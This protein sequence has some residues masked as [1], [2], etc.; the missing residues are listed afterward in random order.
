MPVHVV[1]LIRDRF[2]VAGRSLKDSA[3]LICGVAYKENTDDIRNSHGLEI[4]R[5][6]KAEGAD[7]LLWDPNVRDSISGFR[8]VESV[9]D[10]LGVTDAL[11]FTVRHREFVRLNQDNAIMNLVA[12]MRT[13]IVVDGWGMFQ[14]LIGRK[15]VYYTSVGIKG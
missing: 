8:M 12:K 4:A 7:V 3:V 5:M 11:V 2:A 13:P 1:D 10:V 6:V 15:D 9:S 14:G